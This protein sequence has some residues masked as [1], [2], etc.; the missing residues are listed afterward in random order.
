[1]EAA[2]RASPIRLS[3]KFLFSVH[4]STDTRAVSPSWL[5]G[6]W[7]LGTPHADLLDSFLFLVKSLE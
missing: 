6:G 1:M 3:L 5:A 7:L 2:V 4:R